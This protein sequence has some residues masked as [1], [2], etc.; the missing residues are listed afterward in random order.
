MPGVNVNHSKLV[1]V[2]QAV[3]NK[4][5]IRDRERVEISASREGNEKKRRKGKKR[6]EVWR[7]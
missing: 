6:L 2:K 3:L 4:K 7:K 1:Y 5:S